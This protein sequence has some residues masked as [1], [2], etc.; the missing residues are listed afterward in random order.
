MPRLLLRIAVAVSLLGT[1]A[2][3]QVP[4]LLHYQGLLTDAEGI[5]LE[6]THSLEFRIYAEAM[7]GTP[8]WSESHEIDLD[9]GLFATLLGGTTPLPDDL[10]AA[11]DRYLAVRVDGGSELQPRQR[12]AS[13]AY[14]L[15][16]HDCE[17]LD[18]RAATQFVRSIDGVS[19]A[20][21]N[22]DFIA[23]DNVSI[24]P[25]PGGR[26][27]RID[28]DG[29]ELPLS[30]TFEGNDT[31]L[32]VRNTGEG[33]GIFGS[34][35]TAT[36]VCGQSSGSSGFGVAGIA[37]GS[38]GR[39]VY[40]Q[41]GGAAG[42]GVWGSAPQHHGVHGTTAQGVGVYGEH[43]DSGTF[44]EIA[45][46][47][48][49]VFGEHGGSGNQGALGTSRQ[50]VLGSSVDDPGVLGESET[51]SGVI[52]T[53]EGGSGV[54]GRSFDGAGV[55][56]IGATAGVVGAASRGPGLHGRGTVAVLAEGDIDARGALRGR[57]GSSRGSDGAPFP[58][59]AFDSGWISI[60]DGSTTTL[61]H[62][63]GGDAEDYVIDLRFRSSTLGLHGKALGGDS[64][65]TTGTNDGAYWRNLTGSTVRITRLTNDTRAP[66]IRMRIWVIR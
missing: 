14:A 64:R 47:Q 35:S 59:P 32:T 57:I 9:A 21:G 37:N 54:V 16:A 45:S 27:I 51:D 4:A 42:R 8:L 13:V 7:A 25:N 26:S 29:V 6:G 52:G 56:G 10:F 30:R 44:A 46:G 43:T 20:A 62:D 55:S 60:A 11:A 49:A 36:G 3:A 61:T 18:G 48:A 58:R 39:G 34:S 31:G 1:H 5:P 41:S 53:S 66:E 40:G 28:A 2:A 24:T 12:L 15:S 23:G 63:I 22:V 17:N 33:W 19:P 38:S 50:G 65:N